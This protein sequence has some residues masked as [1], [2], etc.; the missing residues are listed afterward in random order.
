MGDLFSNYNPMTKIAMKERT[1]V[2]CNGR[3]IEKLPPYENF[4]VRLGCNG[5]HWEDFWGINTLT[6]IAM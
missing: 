2:G 5:M 1:A 3:I 6:K 4:H